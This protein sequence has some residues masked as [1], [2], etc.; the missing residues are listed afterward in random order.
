MM[1]ETLL[2]FTVLLGVLIFVHELGH[3]MMA[4]RLGVRVLTFSLGF[5]PKIVRVRRGDTEYCLSAVPLGGYVKMAGETP[6]AERTGRPDEF[7]SRS[8]LARFQILVMGPVM[9][10]VL[11]VVLT[12]AVF[13][14]GADVLAFQD[15]PPVVG[16]VA[17][18]SPA[19]RAGIR[20]GDRILSI[21]GQP[22]AT[23]ED[24]YRSI[25]AG[26]TRQFPVAVLR[27]GESIGFLTKAWTEDELDVAGFGV[28][29]DVSPH[30]VQVM[31]GSPADLAGV[32]PGDLVFSV[33]GERVVFQ[34]RL[35]R[36]ISKHANRRI[37]LTVKRDGRQIDLHPTPAANG[38]IGISTGDAL[39][40][41]QPGLLG[42]AKMSLTQNIEFSRVILRTLGGLLTRKTSVSEL[43]GPI[44]IAQMS[45]QAAATG[46]RLYL[47]LMALISLNLGLINLLPIPVL[48]GG[49]ILILAVEGIGRRDLSAKVKEK[50]LLAGFA[51]LMILMV[52]VIYN[53]LARIFWR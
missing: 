51:A 30:V 1:A 17:A 16:V 35:M 20:A 27:A 15:D 44:A 7:L 23:W 8:K 41:V 29:P 11:A 31:K 33:E 39:K 49:H 46:L 45:G 24:V 48:D 42:A 3:F 28:M 18:G 26:R 2:A 21:A 4:R 38:R 43:S 9:N 36:A 13:A 6:E 32:R 37:T 34:S 22:T 25:G 14:F 10:I 19:E 53:D 12:A 52:T 47:L 40:V 50:V 5:G